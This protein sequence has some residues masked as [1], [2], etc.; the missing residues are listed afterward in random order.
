[1]ELGKDDAVVLSRAGHTLAY[2]VGDFEAGALFIERARV[3][4]PNLS[5]AWYSSG[6]LNVWTGE[7]EMA[8]EHLERFIRISPLDPL[9][10]NVYNAIAFA[11]V[12]AGRYVEAIAYAEKALGDKPNSHEALRLAALSYAL[13][14]RA[15]QAQ[16]AVA[17]LLQIDPA[18]RISNL[19]DLAP[20][21]RAEAALDRS[22]F[23]R[24]FPI[25]RG[26]RR[27]RPRAPGRLQVRCSGSRTL[28]RSDCQLFARRC[29]DGVERFRILTDGARPTS[30]GPVDGSLP[31]SRQALPPR[32]RMPDDIA[33]G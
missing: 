32:R 1:V 15:A 13:A 21:Q 3:L 9:L 18:L 6:W 30:A 28:G 7:P 24:L 5:S 26:G 25:L 16:K 29:A 4:N 11:H 20:L 2:V 27:N 14:G 17:R 19:K 22:T 10:A 33:F 23:P 8:I 12:F 31:M